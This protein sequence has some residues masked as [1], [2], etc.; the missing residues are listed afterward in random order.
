MPERTIIEQIKQLG[1]TQIGQRFY[2]PDNHPLAKPTTVKYIGYQYPR[3]ESFL[4][5]SGHFQLCRQAL[6]EFEGNIRTLF[7]N[8]PLKKDELT[9][10]DFVEGLIWDESIINPLFKRIRGKW[11]TF[12]KLTQSIP[13]LKPVSE[14]LA[15]S[16]LRSQ[17]ELTRNMNWMSGTQGYFDPQDERLLVLDQPDVGRITLSVTPHRYYQRFFGGVSLLIAD[18]GIRY[19]GTDPL[20]ILVRVPR[21]QID[22]TTS[23]ERVITIDS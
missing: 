4:S 5:P 11:R 13:I 8:A 6:A 17:N 16:L 15:W 19:L 7:P 22:G 14:K 23:F 18:P 12:A 10:D 3:Y 9:R 2:L 1:P 21:K 20:P